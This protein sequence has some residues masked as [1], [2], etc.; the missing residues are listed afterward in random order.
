MPALDWTFYGR[1]PSGA[2]T[3]VKPIIGG[4]L[5]YD[6]SRTTARTLSGL[7]W[8]PVELAKMALASDDL[9]VYL[10][11]DGA[12]P[13]LMAT[14]RATEASYQKDVLLNDDG[15]VG[16]LAHIEFAD[17]FVRL[18]AAT[19]F[20]F[21]A[22]IGTPPDVAMGQIADK[23]GLTHAFAGSSGPMASTVVWA[24]FTTYATILND[25]ALQ[26]GHRPPWADRM[27]I[28]RSVAASV[29]GTSVLALDSLLPVQGTIVVTEGYLSAPDRVVCFDQSANSALVGT[30]DAPASAP[31]SATKRGYSIAVP[32]PIQGLASVAQ[33]QASAQAFGQLQM[34]RQLSATVSPESAV[35][36]D[37]PIVLSYLGTYWLVRSWSIATNQESTLALVAAEVTS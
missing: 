30:W 5:G 32:L 3:P 15:T 18:N 2:T 7:A 17:S 20:P 37:G 9:L 27:G 16:D 13:V 23:A 31:N 12:T 1:T 14:M 4:T 6:D 21:T 33:A 25:L 11:I 8:I 36:L 22:T 10:S 24:P 26:A 28:A 35:L 19:E 29:V 34:A